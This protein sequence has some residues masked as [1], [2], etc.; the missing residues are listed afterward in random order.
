MSIY[1]HIDQETFRS[2]MKL[3][4]QHNNIQAIVLDEKLSIEDT[5]KALGDTQTKM[6]KQEKEDIARLWGKMSRDTGRELTVPEPGFHAT[7]HA[8]LKG[9][10]DCAMG[11]PTEWDIEHG[12]SDVEYEPDLLWA[13]YIGRLLIQYERQYPEYCF[14]PRL[15]H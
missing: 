11:N 4:H 12:G 13:I 3:K 1:E 6:V 7:V 8:V 15:G 14:S 2:I 10:F 9:A 5:V